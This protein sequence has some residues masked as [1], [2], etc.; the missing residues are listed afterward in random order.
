MGGKLI[1]RMNASTSQIE[2]V[3]VRVNAVTLPLLRVL[4]EKT[5]AGYN[6]AIRYWHDQL[7]DIYPL[8]KGSQ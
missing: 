6:S 7:A 8:L 4:T 3:W 1:L 2:A 5:T